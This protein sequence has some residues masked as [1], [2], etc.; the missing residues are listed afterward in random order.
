MDKEV[1]PK[2]ILQDLNIEEEELKQDSKIKKIYLI[3]VSVFLTLLMISF[4]FV[5]FPI[6]DI[7]VSLFDSTLLED[8]TLELDEFTIFFLNE[9]DEELQN[10][11][12]HQQ[13]VEFSVCLQGFIEQGDYYI[14]SLYQPVMHEQKFDHVS[15]EPCSAE[16]LLLLHSHPYKRC[17]ASDTDLATLKKTQERNPDTL[18]V[19]MCEPRRFAVYK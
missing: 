14:T 3:G 12:L 19:V 8:N 1:L 5:T 2:E 4:V 6:D 9:T 11:Y 13:D 7:I 17:T 10:I 15:F 18:M 16:S